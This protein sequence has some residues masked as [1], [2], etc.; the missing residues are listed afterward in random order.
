MNIWYPCFMKKPF[1]FQAELF[2]TTRKPDHRALHA[3]DATEAVLDWSKIEPI[4]SSVYA[5]QVGGPSYP[6]LALF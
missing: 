6:L 5:S 2:V 4:L 3:L 1:V